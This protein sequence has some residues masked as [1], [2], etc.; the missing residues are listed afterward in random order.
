M[1]LIKKKKN[2]IEGDWSKKGGK[3]SFSE[4]LTFALRP[5]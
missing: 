5:E 4:D 3:E 2:I 1:Q